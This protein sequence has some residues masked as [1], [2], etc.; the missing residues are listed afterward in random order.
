MFDF[1]S[2]SENIVG[3]FTNVYVLRKWKWIPD[4]DVDSKS[5]YTCVARYPH[6]CIDGDA[7]PAGEHVPTSNC[8][9]R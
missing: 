3:T 9:R 4:I 6:D 5:L 2:R 7:R 1:G 8:L